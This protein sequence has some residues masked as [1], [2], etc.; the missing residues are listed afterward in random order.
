MLA[1]PRSKSSLVT[2]FAFQWLNVRGIDGI[3]P[4]EFIFPTF[5]ANL[6]N[7]FR[8]EMELFIES[9]IREDKSA[10]ELLTA[11][12]TFLNERLALHYGIR[13]VRGDQFRR[14]TLADENRWGLLGKGSVLMVTSYANRTAPV[15]RGA[16][17]LENIMGTPPSPPPPDVE[18]FP[19]NKEG[20]KQL[21]V[22]EIMQL[23]RAKP[24]CNACHGVMDPLGFALE[25]FDAIGA[26][27][28]KDI[29]AGT[30]IDAAGNLVDGTPVSGPVDL[31]KALLKHPEQFVETLTEK[32][33]TYG[34]GRPV[35]YYDM[36]AV[37]RI[38]REAARDNYRFSSIVLGIVRSAPFQMNRVQTI[39]S[40]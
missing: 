28:T 20:A 36:P 9:I 38:V 4:D 6:R 18:G 8:R 7:A 34:L 30:P 21:T 37:R 11:N 1:D 26:W 13:D 16:Y 2:N 10:L 17:L 15:I 33:M 12:Y 3:D 19:E 25:N 24:S 23:H 22:R 32:L 35:E 40:K 29:D 14:V 39:A 31:R 5:D 27:R